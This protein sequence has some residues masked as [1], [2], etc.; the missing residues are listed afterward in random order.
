[1]LKASNRFA[2]YNFREYG[3]RRTR[4]EF[5]KNK[6]EQNPTNVA[7][8]MKSAKENLEML[9]RQSLINSLYSKQKSVLEVPKPASNQS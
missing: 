6:A 8:M 3:L 2:S 9:E 4:E 7:A 5:R 1:M